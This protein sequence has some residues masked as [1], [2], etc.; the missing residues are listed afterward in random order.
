MEGSHSGL[1]RAP[2]KRLRAQK[3]LRGF[4]SLSLRQPAWRS[5]QKRLVQQY[6]VSSIHRPSP[7]EAEG[8]APSRGADVRAPESYYI[9]T[10]GC[11][12]NKADSERLGSALDQLGL[13]EMASAKDA[14]IIVLN[15]CV[16]RQSAEDKVTGA[17][18]LMKPLKTGRPSRILALMGCMV[19]PRHD[20][21]KQRFPFVDVFSRP[22][23]YRPL[24]DLVADRLGVDWEGCLGPLV[25]AQPS[26][27]SYIPI[28]HGC[29]L[30]CTFCIIPYRRGRQ[31]SRPIP[32]VMREVEL[33]VERGVQEITLLGQTVDAYGADLPDEPDLADLFYAL[34]DIPG[35][36]R[37]RF[38]TSH[39]MFMSEQ[40]IRA[41]AELPK[42]CEHINLPVQAGDDTVLE[43]MRRTYTR[44][45]Y[46]H[47]ID[48]IRETVP[49]VSLSTD[50]IVGFCG[51][52]EEQFQSTY[53]LLEEV[54]F[55][56]VHVAP[57]STR[58]GTIAARMLEDTV[59]R[60]E[61]EERLK[62]IEE[63]QE[64]VSREING[65][66]LGETLEVLVDGQGKGK[67]KGRTRTD[68][69]V[70]FQDSDQDFYGH[71]VDVRITH[72]GPWSLQGVPVR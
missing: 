66:L 25:P 1:V 24:L 49:D 17:L 53:D 64:R 5:A 57:Y 28:I 46:L 56:K 15:S 34:H 65:R 47:L 68:K 20:D 35:L 48:R 61:K 71:T 3:V 36:Q 38:L 4:E 54:R 21:L 33:L 60:Q 29:D 7:A 58:P 11:Q 10:I 37:I 70:F 12:M 63:L 42:V 13:R 27:T 43:R 62:R 41:V 51:E 22:Q 9:W 52:T 69:L 67:W 59:S 50:V 30:F 32:E 45:E 39:P 23:E 16:V 8:I 44:N 26:V 31:R 6:V 55:D 14:D 72:M 40:I 18:G 19:G 2:A